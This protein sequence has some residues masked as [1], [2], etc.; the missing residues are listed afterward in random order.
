LIQLDNFDLWWRVQGNTVEEP[1]VRRGG[2]SGVQ[3]LELPPGSQ[4]MLYIKRQTGH[5]YRTLR[6]PLGRPTIQREIQAYR[7]YRRLGICVPKLVYGGVGNSHGQWR[8]LL[9][10]E[11]LEGFVSLE[12]WYRIEAQNYWGE[13]I[14]QQMLYQLAKTLS[15]LHASRWQHGCLYPKHIFVRVNQ[16]PKGGVDIALLDLEKSRRRWRTSWASAEDMKQFR[17]HRGGMLDQDWAVLQR[18]YK[19]SLALRRVI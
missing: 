3:S 5:I 8:G 14:H 17:R 19:H 16:K 1:N 15:C 18:Q 9:V 11:G 4:R 6:Y 10:T 7:E 2:T 13:E 12:D